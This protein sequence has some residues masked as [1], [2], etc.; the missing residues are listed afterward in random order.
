M[1]KKQREPKWATAPISPTC[2]V[3]VRRDGI[4]CDC[5]MA[6]HAAYPAWGGGWMALCYLHSLKHTEATPTDEL[7][8]RGETWA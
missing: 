1:P 5:E 4:T 6:T 3:H 7:I 2:E 8:A